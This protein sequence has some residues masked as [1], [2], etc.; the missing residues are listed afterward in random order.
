M[1]KLEQSIKSYQEEKDKFFKKY[2]NET[3]LAM[4]KQMGFDKNITL[5]L[6][7]IIR[8]YDSEVSYVEDNLKYFPDL[9]I[10]E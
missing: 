6:N 2:K 7:Q 8:S 4:K 5:R 3:D 10:D 1:P 9:N